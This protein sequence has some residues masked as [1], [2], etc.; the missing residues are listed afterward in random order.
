[1]RKKTHFNESYFPDDLLIDQERDGEI[2]FEK[3]TE[4][5][6]K[7]MAKKIHKQGKI[8]DGQIL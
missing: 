2:E 7:P 1:M 8:K 5:L 4:K 3:K 6:S